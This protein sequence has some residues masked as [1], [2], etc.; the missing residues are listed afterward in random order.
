MEKICGIYKITTPTNK[1][2]I[3]QSI[4]IL[5]RWNRYKNLHCKTQSR[6][7]RSLIKYGF[8]SHSFDI[9]ERCSKDQLDEREVYWIGIYNTFNTKHGLNLIDGGRSGKHSNETKSKRKLSL[10]GRTLSD[11]QKRKIGK[12]NTGKIRTQEGLR[13]LSIAHL[14]K[15]LSKESIAKR[16]K[17]REGY[18]HSL[19]S[20]E[21]TR[22]SVILSWGK[23][24]RVLSEETKNKIR[25]G[26]RIKKEKIKNNS[27]PLV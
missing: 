19:E 26:M 23:R 11:E 7:Y 5:V 2:Y 18:N 8:D 6:L 17:S 24:S 15:K 25:E 1:I 9:I 16:N 27:K 12:A 22:Q 10:V 21:K 3:G 14:G 4:N 13:N 20:K